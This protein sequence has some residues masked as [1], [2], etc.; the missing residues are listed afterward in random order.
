VRLRDLDVTDA[1]RA[2]AA[3]AATRS[4]AT[5]AMVHL[6]LT[7]AIMRAQP[8]DLVLRPGRPSSRR[9]SAVTPPPRRTVATAR[10]EVIRA[11]QLQ[12]AA[13]GRCLAGSPDLFRVRLAVDRAAAR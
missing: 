8:K 3:V 2:L 11:R 9:N 4:S 6:A 1:D 5:A 10:G 12:V 13:R 7:R